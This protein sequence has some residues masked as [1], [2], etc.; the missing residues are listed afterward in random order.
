MSEST[1]HTLGEALAGFAVGARDGGVPAPVRASVVERFL[2]TFGICLAAASLDT[3]EAALSTMADAGG[4][5]EAT[6]VVDGSR[7]PAP[8]AAFVNGVLAHSLDFD[9]THLPSVLHPSASVLPAALAAAEALGSDGSATV[10]AGAVGLEICV[11]LGMAGYDPAS[12]S[13]LF[14]ERGQHATSICGAIG[15][16][17]ATALLTGANEAGVLSAM[18]IAASMAGGLIEANRTGGTVK[19][20]HC[21]WAANAGIVAARL[22]RAGFTGPPTVFEGRFGFFQAYLSGEYRASAILD[23]LGQSWEVPRIFFKP[24]PANHFTHTTADAALELRRLGVRPE[25]VRRVHV[26]V[27]QAVLKTVGEPI[28]MKRRP[29]TPYQAQFSAPYV[30]TAALLGGSG[31][32]LGR[33]DFDEALVRS[34][35]RRA[36]MARVTVGSDPKL[37]EIFPNQFPAIVTATLDDGREVRVERL[38]NRGGDLAPLSRTELEVKFDENAKGAVPPEVAERLRTALLGLDG[39]SPA[40]GALEALRASGGTRTARGRPDGSAPATMQA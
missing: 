39:P 6:V 8:S 27:P 31:L 32:G 16:A 24:Y 17:A 29:E 4:R 40:A 3:S 22:A 9:D 33:A 12:R 38:V 2:D 28:E 30:V 20:M 35:E 36:L 18:G 14:F 23:G 37:D 21:G 15:A 7:L 19:R 25:E 5:P 34:E 26:Q 1:E 13:S 11:R 10:A